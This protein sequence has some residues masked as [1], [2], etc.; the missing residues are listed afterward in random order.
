MKVTSLF[1]ITAVVAE[2][3]SDLLVS[4]DFQQ[5]ALTKRH[6]HFWTVIEDA[7]QSGQ[8]GDAIEGLAACLEELPDED[9]KPILV[10]ALEHLQLA[11]NGAG[12]V[13]S[14]ATTVAETAISEGPNGKLIRSPQD[15]FA[16]LYQTFVGDETADYQKRLRGQVAERQQR[17][18]SI[19]KVA[20]G[21]IDVLHET[22]LASTRAFDAMK[23][24]IYTPPQ[25]GYKSSAEAKKIADKIVELQ[26]SVR[27]QYLGVVTASVNQ[28]T[29]DVEGSKQSA[30]RIIG[31]IEDNLPKTAPLSMRTE[32]EPLTISAGLA[33]SQFG[34]KNQGHSQA[35]EQG[36]AQPLEMPPIEIAYKEESTF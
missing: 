18:T 5:R 25:H 10:E 14:A 27:H 23:Y 28:I 17:V 36:Q 21:N 20:Q 34:R 3:Y 32:P 19:L 6:E 31:N 30:G 15:F 8:V 29:S 7:A 11:A 13:G 24:D 33:V 9:I 26:G 12:M 22:R 4:E 1:V 16:K 2:V 35:I